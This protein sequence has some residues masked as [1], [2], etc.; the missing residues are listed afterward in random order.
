M[1]LHELLDECILLGEIPA[2]YDQDDHYFSCRL[3]HL[4]QD[5][6]Q[7]TRARGFAEHVYS[8]AACDRS[9]VA[10][11]CTRGLVLEKAVVNAYYVM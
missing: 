10:D 8:E 9:A 1:E 2:S 6:A 3:C 7:F 11:Y 4:D 5:L